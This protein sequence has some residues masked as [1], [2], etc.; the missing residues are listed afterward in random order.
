M[1]IKGSIEEY[2]EIYCTYKSVLNYDCNLLGFIF[3]IPFIVLFVL[4]RMILKLLKNIWNSLLLFLFKEKPFISE[5]EFSDNM[6]K[7]PLIKSKF[8][9][10]FEGTEDIGILE[11]KRKNDL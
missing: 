2:D 7:N 1:R 10:L 5:E 8:V 4:I 6:K 11:F 3:I 9:H